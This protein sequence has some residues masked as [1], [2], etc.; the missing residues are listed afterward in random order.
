MNQACGTQAEG[1][2]LFLTMFHTD[3][4][5]ANVPQPTLQVIQN[6]R[7]TYSEELKATKDL[8]DSS[9]ATRD[10]R[11]AWND[12]LENHFSAPC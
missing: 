1:V 2:G 11:L 10:S 4:T 12:G 8:A 7:R 6:C 5:S 9:F 3:R